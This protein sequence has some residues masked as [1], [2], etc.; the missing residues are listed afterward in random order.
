[1]LSGKFFAITSAIFAAAVN[2]SP[3]EVAKRDTQPVRS[4]CLVPPD[5]VSCVRVAN[6]VQTLTILLAYVY[7]GN[8]YFCDGIDWAEPCNLFGVDSSTCLQR[9]WRL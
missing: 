2:A 5:L 1:M 8:V 7:L 9:S 6:E 3:V 4:P